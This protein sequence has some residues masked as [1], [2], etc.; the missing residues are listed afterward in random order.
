[1]LWQTY[2]LLNTKDWLR[3][4]LV[5][6]AVRHFLVLVGPKLR[7]ERLGLVSSTPVQELELPLELPAEVLPKPPLSSHTCDFARCLVCFQQT[8]KVKGKHNCSYLR[9]QE[10]RPLRT[11]SKPRVDGTAEVKPPAPQVELAQ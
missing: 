5:A 6:Q 8:G 1:M 9:R 2:V 3:W 7:D 11:T 10:C 4:E